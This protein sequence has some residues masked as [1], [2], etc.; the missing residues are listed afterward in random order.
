MFNGGIQVLQTGI[1][2]GNRNADNIDTVLQKFEHL[3]YSPKT[4]HTSGIKALMLTSFG[5]GQKG[6]IVVAIAPKYV[7][8]AISEGEKTGLDFIRGIM[9]KSLFKAK[10]E[11]AWKNDESAVFLDPRARAV[12]HSATN[13]FVVTAESR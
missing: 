9:S 10:K 3:I 11:S 1:V 8:A 6:G 5:F 2:P 7:F 12:F 4:I 13:E